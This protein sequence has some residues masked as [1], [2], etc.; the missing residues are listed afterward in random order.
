MGV[1]TSDA[2]MHLYAVDLHYALPLAVYQ[3]RQI[4]FSALTWAS[5]LW[6]NHDAAMVYFVSEGNITRFRQT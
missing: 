6:R 5:S 4:I 3:Q 1:R 2:V